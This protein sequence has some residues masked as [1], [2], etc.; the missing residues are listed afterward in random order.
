MISEFL[1]VAQELKDTSDIVSE[2]SGAFSRNAYHLKDVDHYNKSIKFQYPSDPEGKFNIAVDTHTIIDSAIHHCFTKENIGKLKGKRIYFSLD[3]NGTGHLNSV[4][5]FIKDS[6]L[7]RSDLSKKE[8]FQLFQI[9]QK[10]VRFE[11]SEEAITWAHCS[12][13]LPHRVK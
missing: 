7:L 2:Y 13:T 12:W 8:V 3:V 10:E 5:L 6:D 4:M 9:I 1:A 11:V